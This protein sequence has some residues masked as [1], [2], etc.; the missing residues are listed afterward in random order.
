MKNRSAYLFITAALFCIVIIFVYVSLQKIGT[1]YKQGLSSVSTKIQDAPMAR[2][3]RKVRRITV[4]QDDGSCLELTS[5]GVVRSFATCDGTITDVN[6]LADPKHLL[7]LFQYASQM[8]FAKFQDKPTEGNYTTLTIETDQG[9][10]TVYVPYTPGGGGG[11]ADPPIEDVID[12]IIGDLP[13]PTQTPVPGQPTNTPI[14]P[15]VTITPTDTPGPTP[16]GGTTPTPTWKPPFPFLCDF[17][18]G[19]TKKKPYYISG[20]ICSTGPTPIL[21]K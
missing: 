16:I 18:D 8:D 17:S 4:V 3:A 14:P 13:Q 11:G 15:G 20:V 21:Q 6:R 10:V 12:T 1:S 5:D 2:D 7:K 19:S 9:S